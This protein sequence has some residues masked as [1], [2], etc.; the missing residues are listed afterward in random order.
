MCWK[1]TTSTRGSGETNWMTNGLVRFSNH[2]HI[3][4]CLSGP[5]HKAPRGCVCVW[6]CGG[7]S[8]SKPFS[9]KYNQHDMTCYSLWPL[10]LFRISV[11]WH[12]ALIQNLQS[13]RATGT[14]VSYEKKHG[15]HMGWSSEAV[16]TKP[17]TF[18]PPHTWFHICSLSLRVWTLMVSW[19]RR[20]WTVE[21][22]PACQVFLVRSGWG[23]SWITLQVALGDWWGI[24]SSL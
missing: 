15:K 3:D 18:L 5:D 10:N 21:T 8:S 2:K 1:N 7:G 19:H 20:P 12:E 22:T 14:S 6:V 17:W 9:M 16:E 23:L 4:L 24:C 13:G 11:S